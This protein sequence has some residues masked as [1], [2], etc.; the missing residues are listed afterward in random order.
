MNKHAHFR[1]F[2]HSLQPLRGSAL[3]VEQA[4]KQPLDITDMLAAARRKREAGESL[5]A[6]IE[7]QRRLLRIDNRDHDRECE[8][9]IGEDYER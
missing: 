9:E 3:L 8:R 6:W 7:K 1:G 5:S 4:N 2:L